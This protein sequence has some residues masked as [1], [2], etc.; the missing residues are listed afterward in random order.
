MNDEQNMVDGSSTAEQ[1]NDTVAT[2]QKIDPELV[3]LSQLRRK[4]EE[5]K[6]NI[7]ETLLGF[8]AEL[9]Q[10]SCTVEELM[11]LNDFLTNSFIS[12]KPYVKVNRTMKDSIFCDYFSVREHVLELHRELYPA[13]VTVTASDIN[14]LTIRNVLSRDIYNDLGYLVHN[15]LIVLVEAQSTWS[16]N[17]LIRT[18]FYLTIT[19]RRYVIDHK[20]DTFQTDPIELPPIQIFVIYTGKKKDIPSTI[21]FKKEFKAEIGC[22]ELEAKVLRLSGENTI[23]DQYI[24]V[25]NILDQYLHGVTGTQ[26]R[27]EALSLAIDE[28]IA[29][30]Y[31]KEYLEDKRKEVIAMLANYYHDTDLIEA[32]VLRRV[33][34]ARAEGAVENRRT[35]VLSLLEANFP[36]LQVSTLLKSPFAEVA[37]VARE[38]NIPIDDSE[39]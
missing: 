15:Q 3:Y 8:I 28:C 10:G 35:N 38:H 24:H 20:L 11:E 25:C 26:E 18:L 37:A 2:S 6:A 39:S 34:I 22:L 16:T 29:R 21:S 5:D 12:T 7:K 23:I 31:M 1:N 19:Y 30:G 17:I 9:D 14:I 33:D 13:D 4:A 36:A 32:S 27:V